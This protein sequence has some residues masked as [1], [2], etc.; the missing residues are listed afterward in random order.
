MDNF[1]GIQMVY[2]N[3]FST[4]VEDNNELVAEIGF[5]LLPPPPAVAVLCSCCTATSSGTAAAS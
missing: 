1:F 3:P 2:E 4:A 5:G